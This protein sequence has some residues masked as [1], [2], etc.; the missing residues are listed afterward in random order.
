MLLFILGF[1]LAG[2]LCG[3]VV[4]WII[5]EAEKD[6]VAEQRAGDTW[7]AL[8]ENCLDRNHQAE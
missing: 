4:L 1:C 5:S 2:V 3:L 7:K 8:Y 6:I